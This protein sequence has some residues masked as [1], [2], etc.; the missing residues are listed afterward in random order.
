[1]EELTLQLSQAPLVAVAI[2]LE[3]SVDSDYNW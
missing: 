1:M 3:A 2:A